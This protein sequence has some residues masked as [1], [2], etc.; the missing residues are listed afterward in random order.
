MVEE[1]RASRLDALRAKLA[2]R[3]G[4]PGFKDNVEAIKKQIAELEAEATYRDIA[5]GQFVAVE[6]AIQNPETTERVEP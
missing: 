4:K 6:Y 5:S 2:A 1:I 3:E